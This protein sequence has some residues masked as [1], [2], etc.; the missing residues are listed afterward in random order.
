MKFP[1]FANLSKAKFLIE[2]EESSSTHRR[3]NPCYDKSLQS[4]P[5]LV[6]D[7]RFLAS[8]LLPLLSDALWGHMER[9][10]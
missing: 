2:G 8:L 4:Q 7:A 9:T 1:L 3:R 10:T 5:I 6:T